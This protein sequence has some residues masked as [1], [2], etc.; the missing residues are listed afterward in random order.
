MPI[1]RAV[2]GRSQDPR[3][4]FAEELRSCRRQYGKTLREVG[5]E[6]TWD[7]S[8]LGRM[9]LGE[10]LGGPE[11]VQDLDRL[12]RTNYLLIL[13]ELAQKDPSQFRARYRRY[14]AM[15]AE[16][17]GIQI[18]SPAIVPGLLQTPPYAEAVLRAGGLKGTELEAQVKARIGR[19]DLLAGSKPPKLRAIVSEA[20]L[21]TPIT[22][23]SEWREQL[24]ALID[25]SGPVDVSLQVVP[26]ST[27]PHVLA[28]TYVDF[29]RLPSA[30]TVAWVETSHRGELVEETA[31]VEHLLLSYDRV[32]DQALSVAET[33]AL[34]T[35]LVE[36]VPCDSAST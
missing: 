28:N 22:H 14:M 34:I 26:L 10:T 35:N 24:R 19:Q 27:G 25:S 5:R 16:A 29:L 33:H 2:T 11:M 4:R 15:E 9:E 7:H 20:A 32:R 21:R 13:W 1:R 3:A 31:A 6:I 30:V 8:H 23:A 12:Y 18:Y 17:T 36:G